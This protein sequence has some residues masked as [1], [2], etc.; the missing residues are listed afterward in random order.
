MAFRFWRRPKVYGCRVTLEQLEDRIV[1]D[2]AAGASQQI[3]DH[4]HDTA[5]QAAADLQH[6][7]SQTTLAVATAPPGSVTPPGQVESQPSPQ[8]ESLGTVV[9]HNDLNVVMVSNDL[10]DIKGISDASTQGSKV[11]VYDAQNDNLTSLTALLDQLVQSTGQ[12]IDN[13]AVVGHAEAG[14][15]TI[16]SDEITFF[17]VS[18]FSPMFSAIAGDLSAD[19]QIQFFGCSLAQD[20]FGQALVDRIAAFTGADVFASTNTTGGQWHDWTLEY[21]SDTSVT[22]EVVLDTATMASSDTEALPTSPGYATGWWLPKDVN[23]SGDAIN[24]ADLPYTTNV[25]GT[26]FFVATDGDKGSHHKELWKTDGTEVGTVMVE[27]INLVGDGYGGTDGSNP[28]GLV[29][30]NGNLYFVANDGVNGAELW[31]S[32]GTELGTYMVADLNPT[33]GAGS[34]PTGLT[35][36]GSHL[37]FA[38]DDGSGS[39]GMELYRTDGTTV[40]LVKDVNPGA[41]SSGPH[42]LT[43]VGSWLYFAAGDA[44]RGIELWRTDGTSANTVMIG[45]ASFPDINPAGNAFDST[46]VPQLE[47]VADTDTL[48][49]AAYDS[50]HGNELWKI[51]NAGTTSGLAELVVDIV[52]G[53]GDG[54]PVV[55]QGS[56]D[57]KAME[58]MGGVLYFT[59]YDATNGWELWKSDG[60]APGTALVMDINPSGDSGADHFVSTGTRIFFAAN[61]G[62][63]GTEPWVTDGTLPGTFMVADTQVGAVGGFYRGFGVV[64][65]LVIFSADDG[66]TGVEPWRSDGTLSGTFMRGDVEPRGRRQL[67]C[68]RR[69]G[70][71]HRDA[72]RCS[73]I[74][75]RT[76]TP[77][78]E[79]RG[80]SEHTHPAAI[81]PVRGQPRQSGQR[82]AR[83]RRFH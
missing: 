18:Q 33:A 76:R 19:A 52:P 62:T 43:A 63:H 59:G 31:R 16:G 83:K 22:M 75:R 56:G 79:E 5:H 45:T 65:S 38:A 74:N 47:Y 46:W 9:P 72:L 67:S 2:A 17:N 82:F 80:P 8:T 61:D 48:F 53:T 21:S 54:V 3:D 57:G 69:V 60:T 64:G 27:D 6:A 70:F 44:S 13:L 25:D 26:I 37:Y 36:M 10:L 35:V 66:T 58:S 14:L 49:F 40:E 1:L 15:L 77:G 12:K 29:G 23:E 39:Y 4:H 50:V 55:V 41:V 81:S 51:S 34:N 71:S 24:I 7:A 42:G 30:F 73:N 68:R 32:D 28:T 20:A 11:I 78:M